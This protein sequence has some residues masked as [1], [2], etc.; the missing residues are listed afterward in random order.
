MNGNEGFFGAF[1]K[2]AFVVIIVLLLVIAWLNWQM[3]LFGLLFVVVAYL[4]SS[5]AV[6]KQ[7]QQRYEQFNTIAKGI[8]QASNFALQNLPTAI[9]IIDSK[10]RV[11]WYNS[12]FRDWMPQDPDKTQRR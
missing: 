1:E 12:V 6:C 8:T 9:V 5:R 4:Y 10:A 3:A 11:C 7:R 2:T